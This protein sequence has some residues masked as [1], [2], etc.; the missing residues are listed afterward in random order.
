MIP[1][2]GFSRLPAY[3]AAMV[4]PEHKRCLGCGY[5]LDGLPE[6]RCPECGRGFD[7]DD[8]ETFVEST[9]DARNCFLLAIAGLAVLALGLAILLLARQI[10]SGGTVLPAL[11]WMADLSLL[12]DLLGLSCAA[13]A[14]M[15]AVCALR[16]PRYSIVHRGE[17]IAAIAIG[18]LPFA[19]LAYIMIRFH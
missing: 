4:E 17:A 8:A 9:T 2:P 3:N 16:L 13:T 10:R 18:A 7:P 6:P 12:L 15:R 19:A 11:E 1:Q 14:L 5:I